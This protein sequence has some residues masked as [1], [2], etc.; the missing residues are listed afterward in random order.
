VSSWDP[1]SEFPLSQLNPS[2]VAIQQDRFRYLPSSSCSP[3]I[4]FLIFVKFLCKPLLLLFHDL[5]VR[6]VNTFR[7]AVQPTGR[8]LILGRGERYCSPLKLLDRL[9]SLLG[10]KRPGHEAD[11]IARSVSIAFTWKRY[12]F[13]EAYSAGIFSRFYAIW[14]IRNNLIAKW[15][16]FLTYA[17]SWRTA[18]WT[19]N[20]S[21]MLQ[22]AD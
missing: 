19:L 9:W 8:S 20:S 6:M 21:G 1:S 7:W 10:R 17:K 3:N 16:I 12:E 18:S 13:F 2:A 5:I 4:F 11:H 22:R 15:W 14:F